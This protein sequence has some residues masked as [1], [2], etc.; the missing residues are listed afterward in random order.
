MDNQHQPSA[1]RKP[2]HPGQILKHHYLE[3]L[4]VSNDALAEMLELSSETVSDLVY[5]KTDITPELA[6]QLSIAFGTSQEMWLNLQQKFDV[7]NSKA[8]QAF[9]ESEQERSEVY[10][11]LAES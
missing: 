11:R 5:G 4:G 1:T 8:F 9:L 2:I 10:R 7:Q 6:F 3:P